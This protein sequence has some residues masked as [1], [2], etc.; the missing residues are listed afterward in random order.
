MKIQPLAIIFL[1][2]ALSGASRVDV[3]IDTAP[4]PVDSYQD[5]GNHIDYPAIAWE[6]GHEGEIVIWAHVNQDGRTGAMGG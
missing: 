3:K 1:V 2:G 6:A 5:I 4:T